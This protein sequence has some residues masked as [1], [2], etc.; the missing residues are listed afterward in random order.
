MQATNI[1][2]WAEQTPEE[3]VTS[4]LITKIQMSHFFGFQGELRTLHTSQNQVLN[5]KI[6]TYIHKWFPDPDKAICHFIIYITAIHFGSY[7]QSDLSQ[8]K[9]LM[10]QVLMV[11]DLQVSLQYTVPLFSNIVL[12][13]SHVLHYYYS[14]YQSPFL[15]SNLQCCITEIGFPEPY[16][17]FCYSYGQFRSELLN[18]LCG[19]EQILFLIRVHLGK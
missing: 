6:G 10:L 4:A 16:S 15:F 9:A 12:N 13:S 5:L 8:L 17:L 3:E 14:F 18:L 19:V 11:L 2:H 7:R 1:L